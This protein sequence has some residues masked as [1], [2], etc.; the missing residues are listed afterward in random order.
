MDQLSAP[1]AVRNRNQI[2]AESA[3]IAALKKI[4]RDA[5]AKKKCI[6]KKMPSDAHATIF[7]GAG[8]WARSGG[9]TRKRV[10]DL[11]LR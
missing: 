11:G 6:A 5:H 7:F 3:V 10:C 2:A 9:Q 1:S 8:G 4:A